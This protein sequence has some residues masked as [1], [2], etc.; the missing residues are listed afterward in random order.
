M[1][2]CN[3]QC[4]LVIST[5]LISNNRL[6]QSEYKVLLKH[7]NLTTGNKILWKKGEIAPEEQVLLSIVFSVY[8]Y[9]NESNNIFICEKWLFDVFFP[10]FCKFDMSRYGCFREFLELRENESRL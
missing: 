8:L 1:R 5:T 2:L 4:T 3:R 9:I 6:S 10:Q 7:E